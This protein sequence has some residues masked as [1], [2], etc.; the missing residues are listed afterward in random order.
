M[1]TKSNN[2]TIKIAKET[3]L[4]R[5]GDMENDLYFVTKGRLLICSRSGHMVTPIAYLNKDDYFGEMSFFDNSSRSADVIAVEDTTLV[6]IPSGSIKDQFPTWLLVIAKQMTQ[7]LRNMDNVIR[8]KG[9]K[10]KNIDSMTPLTID[11]Q[12]HFYQLLNED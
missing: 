5:E 1:K 3:I 2:E 12:R 6:K 4:C 7:K 8:D 11:E 9:I 10:R